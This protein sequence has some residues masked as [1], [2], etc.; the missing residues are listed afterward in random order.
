VFLSGFLLPSGLTPD[1]PLPV[2][3]FL[4]CLSFLLLCDASFARFLSPR[5]SVHASSG[6]LHFP[7]AVS[8]D[9]HLNPDAPHPAVFFFSPPPPPPPKGGFHCG[10]CLIFPGLRSRLSFLVAFFVSSQPFDGPRKC[11][12]SQLIAPFSYRLSP[13]IATGKLHDLL[14]KLPDVLC[15]LHSSLTSGRSNRTEA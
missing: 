5:T 6:P 11:R 7:S 14:P 12:S 2:V 9:P 4:M 8:R 13:N 1:L 15:S 10:N 3:K